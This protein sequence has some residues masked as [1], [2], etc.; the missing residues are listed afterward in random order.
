MVDKL[1][2][3]LNLLSLSYEDAVDNLLK[4]YGSVKDDY[5][6]ENSYKRFFAGEIK[7]I[8]KGKYSRATEDGLYCHHVKEDEYL[9]LANLSFLKEQ[10]PPYSVQKRENLVYCDLIEHFIL[11]LLIANKTNNKYGLPGVE[12]YLLPMIMDWY[13]AA[14]AVP[15]KGWAKTCYDKA[16]VTEPEGKKIIEKA[17]EISPQNARL[18]DE[19]LFRKPY[20]STNSIEDLIELLL[21]KDKSNQEI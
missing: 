15:T 16:Y 13:L 12:N 18:I 11:H 1:N 6:R 9:N 21:S 14:D 3:Y 10:K 8:T 2:G 5:F 19:I 17:K 7:S 20:D 4:K